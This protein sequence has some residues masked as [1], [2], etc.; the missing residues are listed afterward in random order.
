MIIFC[1]LIGIFISLYLVF[2]TDFLNHHGYDLSVDGIVLARALFIIF[3]LY[4]LNNIGQL[5]E[6]MSQKNNK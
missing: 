2:D 5:Y 1:N 6:N 3:A 4:C